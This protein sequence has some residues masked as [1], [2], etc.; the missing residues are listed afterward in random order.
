MG[1]QDV[2]NAERQPRLPAT[3][4]P[5]CLAFCCFVCELLSLSLRGPRALS[6]APGAGI[7][8]ANPRVPCSS[9]CCFPTSNGDCLLICTSSLA[10]SRRQEEEESL[11]PPSSSAVNSSRLLS[12]APRF[13]YDLTT[14]YFLVRVA[15]KHLYWLNHFLLF[16]CLLLSGSSTQTQCTLRSLM[17]P[18]HNN[19]HRTPP[20]RRALKASQQLHALLCMIRSFTTATKLITT[21]MYSS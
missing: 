11:G 6:H 14:F 17:D 20:P 10:A 7:A 3:R 9:C 4:G 15:S 21:L 19:T 18:L 1:A 16:F 2:F 13:A 5:E 12:A 8:S